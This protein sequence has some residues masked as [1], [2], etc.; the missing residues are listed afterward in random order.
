MGHC[1][2]TLL[3]GLI[4]VNGSAARKRSSPHVLTVASPLS[5]TMDP[6][7]LPARSRK[8]AQPQ[9]NDHNNNNPDQNPL[10]TGT[11]GFY[12]TQAEEGICPVSLLLGGKSVL[13]PCRCEKRWKGVG[14][15]R[16]DVGPGQ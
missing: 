9:E 6:L 5:C 2:E 13:S 4:A 8:I 14:G 10:A 1:H 3:E 11:P 16:P 12:T 15:L 7:R